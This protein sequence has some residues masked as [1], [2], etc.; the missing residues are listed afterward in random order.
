MTIQTRTID[1]THDGVTFE[2][3]L[4]WDDTASGPRPA[5]AVAHAWAGRSAFEDGKARALAEAG[6]V[7]FA[8]DVY[9]K[10]KRGSNN[11]ENAALMT[12]LVQ[13][14]PLLQAR[15][16]A[17]LATLAQQPEVDA[18]RL[19]AIGFCFGGLSVL[20]MARCGLPLRG[21]VSFHGLF[22]PPGNTAGRR[23]DAKV[24]ALHG[25]D[26]PMAK[27]EAVLAFAQ[28][29]TAAGADWQLHAYGGTMH[30]FTNPQ[31]NDPGFG[32]VYSARADARSWQ[33]MR[34]FLA[35]VLA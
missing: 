27:P 2:G 22:T 29:M 21:V 34:N 19:A 33:A 6:Y 8:M 28:E 3:L 24:L 26:D 4:A 16:G 23:I 11:E 31:A 12:P 14:R 5:V 18:Q 13:N 30:A 35:E 1:Y 17:A 9:G 20:D 10:G 25:W 32:T 7:G 15:L